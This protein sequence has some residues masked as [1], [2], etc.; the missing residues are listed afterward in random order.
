M[1]D[2]AVH[3]PLGGGRPGGATPVRGG[4]TVTLLNAIDGPAIETTDHRA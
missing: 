4:V 2:M 3:A 1:M